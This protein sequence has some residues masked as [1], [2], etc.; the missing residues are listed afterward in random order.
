VDRRGRRCSERR[1]LEFHHRLPHALGG[2]RTPRNIAASAPAT[3]HTR[4]CTAWERKSRDHRRDR[5]RG[6]TVPRR[7]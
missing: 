6:T 5:A 2:D 3:T 4:R 7:A 1:H